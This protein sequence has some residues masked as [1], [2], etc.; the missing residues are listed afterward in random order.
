MGESGHTFYAVLRYIQ[1]CRP[2][3]VV[4]ENVC[5]APWG[6]IKQTMKDIDYHGYHVKVD[7][8]NYYLPQT[9]ERGYMLCIDQTKLVTEPPGNSKSSIFSRMMKNLERPASSPV[10]K[11]LLKNDDPRLRDAVNDIS[12]ASA[13][14]RQSVDWTRYKARHLGYRMREGLGDKRPLTKWQ[15][16]GTCQ[17]PDFY[18]H[19]WSRSQT[20]RVW[21]TLDV[22]YLRTIIRGYD[23]SFK[24]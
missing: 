18:W 5:S 17:M 9:R 14:D 6:S 8:K 22:N 21:D 16:N 11:F 13:K 10:T 19:G 1:R 12:A 2:A 4:L 23:I 24:S 20:E 7:T 3:L 15:D